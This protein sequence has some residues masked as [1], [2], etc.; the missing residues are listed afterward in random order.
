MKRKIISIT[1]ALATLLSCSHTVY[2]ENPWWDDWRRTCE[3]DFAGGYADTSLSGDIWNSGQGTWHVYSSIA[4]PAR[5]QKIAAEEEQGLLRCSWV[6]LQGDSRCMIGAVHN[7]GNGTYELDPNSNQPKLIADP[8]NWANQGPAVN[9]NANEIVWISAAAM[10]NHEPFNG[11]FVWPED[12]MQ[13]TYPD[14]SSALG[15]LNDNHRDP[16]NY[17]LYD[18]MGAKDINGDLRINE[19]N[20]QTAPAGTDISTLWGPTVPQADGTIRFTHN[21]YFSKDVA[22]PW[23]LEYNRIAIRQLLE[24]GIHGFWVDNYAGWDYINSTPTSKGFGEWSV[25]KFRDYIKEHNDVLKIDDIDNFDIRV[26]LKD[27]FREK[28]PGGNPDNSGDGN[29]SSPYW[30][31]D[32]VWKAYCA[33]KVDVAHQTM[34]DFYAMVKE[35]A[36]KLGIDPDQIMVSG[37]DVSKLSFGSEKSTQLDIVSTEHSSLGWTPDKR[38]YSDG[39]APD[40]TSAP[41]YKTMLAYQKGSVTFPWYYMDARFKEYDTLAEVEWYTA[42]INNAVIKYGS[43]SPGTVSKIAEINKNVEKM[44]NIYQKR[45]TMAKIAI[46]RSAQTQGSYWVPRETPFNGK[47]AHTLDHLGW[48]MVLEE[49]N[50]PYK[51]LTDYQ[52]DEEHLKD[53]DLLILPTVTC[54]DDEEVEVIR[55]YADRGGKM[56]VSGDTSGLQYTS[57]YMWE[58][59]DRAVLVDLALDPKYAGNI[60]YI[61]TSVGM[62][63]YI[64]KNSQFNVDKTFDYLFILDTT[65][66]IATPVFKNQNDENV[67]SMSGLKKLKTSFDFKNNDLE[68]IDITIYAQ[69][70]DEN[71]WPIKTV[72]KDVTAKANVQQPMDIEIDIP[73]KADDY[74]VNIFVWKDNKPITAA[75]SFPQQKRQRTKT[76]VTTIELEVED[77]IKEGFIPT[78]YKL[79]GFNSYIRS[80]FW[81]KDDTNRYFLDLVNANYD[82]ETDTLTPVAGGV[83]QLE[84]AE[85]AEFSFMDVDSSEQIP[86]EAEYS[87]GKYT[88]KVPSFRVCGSIII[89]LK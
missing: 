71:G 63:Y 54:I 6:E 87:N 69:V 48:G 88:I 8:W 38:F 86:L 84:F 36:E 70:C 62:D 82:I 34:I 83:V 17:K 25:A 27:T 66:Q 9:P 18:A 57:D 68:N 41:A 10:V 61:S 79:Y 56:F 85:G 37:N 46:V 21:F 59:R 11:D 74:S 45:H 20:W 15:W 65:Y 22:S 13:P 35:E 53:V 89:D 32:K 28:F 55:A 16:R 14:G 12:A 29:W 78:P 77:Y 75:I 31:E 42:L 30:L 4:N 43:R 3:G 67:S 23:W 50:I 26:Y 52:L 81:K 33:Y 58:K 73:E 64:H 80:A 24:A 47:V 49:N 60:Q 72:S 51:V 39:L 1:V 76:S 40:G 5:S 7:L 44:G 2:A 19:P